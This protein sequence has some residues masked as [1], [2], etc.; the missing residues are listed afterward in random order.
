MIVAKEMARATA[1]SDDES[2]RDRPAITC[3]E[4]VES[5]DSMEPAAQVHATASDENEPDADDDGYAWDT[6]V[7]GAGSTTASESQLDA[8]AAELTADT[9]MRSIGE[10]DEWCDQHA[11]SRL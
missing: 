9:S 3:A 11:R 1:G 4:A 5:A 8:L 10:P 7:G 6:S 2:K